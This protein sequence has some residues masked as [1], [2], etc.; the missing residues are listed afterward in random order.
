MATIH[1]I[2]KG[3]VQGVFYRKNAREEAL[4]LGVTGWIRNKDDGDVEAMVS[5]DP[6]K[7]VQFEKWCKQGPR[8]A[9]VNEV[10]ITQCEEKIFEK[11]IIK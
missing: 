2:I 3:K 10:I 6:G 8:L 5:A 7:L 4:S 9:E 11:F 1:L